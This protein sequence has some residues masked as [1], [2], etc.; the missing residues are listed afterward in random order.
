TPVAGRGDSALDPLIGFFANTLVLRTDTSGDPDFVTLLDRVRRT[1]LA[2]YSHQ[3]V[4]FE[5][6]VD[7]LGVERSLARNPLVQ[8]MLAFDQHREAALDLDGGV[9][10]RPPHPPTGYAAAKYDLA[11]NVA[12]R[13]D[14]PD[15]GTPR[16]RRGLGDRHGPV[17][18]TDRRGGCRTPGALPGSGGGRS[19]ATDRGQYAWS[20]PPTSSPPGTTRTAPSPSST[21]WRPLNGRS[22]T[23]ATATPSCAARTGSAIRSSTRGPTGWLTGSSRGGDRC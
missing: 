15:G 22:H 4:P 11:V 3:D 8:V 1:D 23:T 10:V 18:P 7:V 13:R 2:A 6:L 16:A 5:R 21:R 17:R 14:P 20:R 12:E 9:G 19:H